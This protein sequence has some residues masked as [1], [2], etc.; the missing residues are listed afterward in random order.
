MSNPNPAITMTPPPI[1]PVPPGVERPLWSVM[2]PTFNCAKYLRQ[3]LES[4][5]AQDPGSE[6]MQIEVIDD[7]STKDNPEVVVREVGKGRVAFY[8]K[9]KNAGA[10]ANFNTCIERSRGHLVHILHGDD[11]VEPGFYENL[12]E[13]FEQYAEVGICITRAFMVDERGSID[14]LSP[15]IPQ[16]EEPASQVEF[17]YYSNPVRTPGVVVRRNLYEI[18]GGFFLTLIHTADWEM[19]I[20]ICRLSR[21]LFINKPLASYRVFPMNDT[22]RLARTGENLRDHLRFAEIVKSRESKFN[23]VLF[24]NEMLH[25][26]RIQSERFKA[27]GDLTAFEANWNVYRAILAKQPLRRKA[28]E[29]IHNIRAGLY[30]SKSRYT[31]AV[32]A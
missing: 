3:T 22:G 16:L 25:R 12:C 10:I 29:F 18:H 23:D 32:K 24:M 14:Y 21:G 9:Q 11:W 13:A 19:W 6:H 4:V 15:R 7:C 31:S 28:I 1:A 30:T 5:L 20:R 17:M 8:R 27:I 2:I 26:A